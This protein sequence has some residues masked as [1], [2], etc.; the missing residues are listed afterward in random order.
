MWQVF[1]DQALFTVT[2]FLKTNSD[3]KKNQGTEVI[4]SETTELNVM[5]SQAMTQSRISAGSYRQS[6]LYPT[7]APYTCIVTEQCMAYI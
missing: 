7:D 1:I 5:L 3:F 2:H 4:T 6:P